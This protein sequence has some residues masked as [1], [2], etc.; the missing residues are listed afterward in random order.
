MVIVF[1][2]TLYG[3]S[4]MCV[5]VCVCRHETLAHYALFKTTDD[6][7]KKNFKLLDGGW[8]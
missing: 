6:V 1:I 4:C 5:C 3:D 2:L 7:C 8:R